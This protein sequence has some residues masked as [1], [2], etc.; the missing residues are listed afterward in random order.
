MGNPSSTYILATSPQGSTARKPGGAGF[1][2]GEIVCS[3][4]GAINWTAPFVFPVFTDTAHIATAPNGRIYVVGNGVGTAGTTRIL[5]WRSTTTGCPAAAL[6]FTGPTAVA[7]NLTFGAVGIDREF[8]QPYVVVDQLNSD[9]VYVAW[10]SDRLAGDG[11][12]DIFLARC[13]FVGTSGTCGA[14]VRIN[15]NPVGD[16]TAQYFPMLCISPTNQILLSWNDRRSGPVQI[17]HTEIDG[18]GMSVN[19]NFLTSEVGFIPFDFGGTPDYGDYSE[20]NQAC[21]GHLYL[22]WSSQVS[23]RGLP[24]PLPTWM[25]LRHG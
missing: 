7:D 20:N 18:A 14:P 1:T 15:D 4:D 2:Q 23:L 21:D 17:F 13:D 9:R 5:L 19:P 24:C 22:A 6:S 12:R 25:C 11:D 3:R 8:P 16:I 10:S